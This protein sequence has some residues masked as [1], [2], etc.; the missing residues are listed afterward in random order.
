MLI[1]IIITSWIL[2]IILAIINKKIKSKFILFIIFILYP[3]SWAILLSWG[4]LLYAGFFS[5]DYKFYIIISFFY[6]LSASTIFLPNDTL[7]K[8]KE[9]TELRN[10][11]LFNS[12]FLIAI[13]SYIIIGNSRYY[14][15][16]H[17]I[18]QNGAFRLSTGMIIFSYYTMLIL[19]ANIV[20]WEEKNPD[21]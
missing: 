21:E 6:L 1:I 7:R 12:L 9:I 17:G 18:S 3:K 13:F 20:T 16:I 8:I 15:R 4:A 11:N 19:I 2:S 14:I 10:N 5:P